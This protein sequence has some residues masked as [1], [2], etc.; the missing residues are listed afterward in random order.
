MEERREFPSD[1][2]GRLDCLTNVVNTEFKTLTLLSLGNQPMNGSDIRRAIRDVVGE[3]VYLPHK[4]SFKAY[5]EHTLFPIGVVAKDSYKGDGGIGYSLTEEGR[6]YGFPIAAF[7]LDWAIINNKSLYNILGSTTSPGERR[8]PLNKIN[9]LKALENEEIFSVRELTSKSLVSN[10]SV[11]RHIPL[12]AQ[13]G[14]VY[15]NSGGSLD[16]MRRV[17]APLSQKISLTI[18][19]TSARI[20]ELLIENPNLLGEEMAKRIGVR[21]STISYHL[22]S[23]L[24]GGVIS[25]DL[26]KRDSQVQIKALGKSFLE[27]FAYPAEDIV[28]DGD[29]LIKGEEL[30]QTIHSDVEL[31]IAYWTKALEIY[32]NA[33]PMVNHSSGPIGQII[34]YLERNPYSKPFEIARDL[35]KKAVTNELR[36]LLGSGKIVKDEKSRYSLA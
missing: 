3:G 32:R 26:K 23:L 19:G 28:R 31:K 16:G 11:S 15:Y 29:Y 18:K 33:S 5:C 1:P 20:L 17:N 36:K 7:A 24:E 14:L 8:S 21:G 9:I 27:G 10:G 2:D 25:Y 4:N 6:K 12:M 30:Y 13:E 22:R 34:N 35:G